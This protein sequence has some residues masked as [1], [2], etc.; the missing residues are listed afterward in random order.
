M[1]V[2]VG[3]VEDLRESEA[4]V[5]LAD[6]SKRT[7][8]VPDWANVLKGLSVRVIEA[9]NGE[10]Q[11]DWGLEE[12][13]AERERV[14]GYVRASLSLLTTDQGG[15]RG[16]FAS[17]YRPQWDLGQRTE[18]GHI[19][20]SD[21]EVWLEDELMLPPGAAAVVR[22]H[23][24]FPEFWEDVRPGAVL[25]LYEGNTRLGEAEVLEVVRP[26]SNPTP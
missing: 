22:L 23:P 21:A 24:F 10:E 13:A 7:L 14:H 6:G 9:S 12:R 4:T 16:P 8:S 3:R 15:R 19:L 1:R 2:S 17:G 18:D 5:R 11:V 26:R 20:F 25:G